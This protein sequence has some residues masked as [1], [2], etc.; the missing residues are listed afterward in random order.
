MKKISIMHNNKKM[1]MRNFGI[2]ILLQI[3]LIT[4]C[5][6]KLKQNATTKEDDFPDEI[7][8]FSPYQSNPIFSGTGRETW[9]NQIRERGYIIKED[10]TYKMWFSG[11]NGDISSPKYLGYATSSD[12]ISWTRHADPI[13][14]KKWTEDIFVIKNKKTYYMFA[15][16]ENDIAHLLTSKDGLTWTEQGNLV[17]KKTNGETIP[18][19]YGTPV[20]W[21]ENKKWYLFYEK[22][23]LGIWAATSNDLINWTNIVD[24][25]VIKMGPT[26]YDA[27]AV[28]ANQIIKHKEKYYLYYHGS[29]NPNWADPNENALW[30]SSV[31]MSK[32]LINWKK[33]PKNPIIE[34]DYSSPILIKEGS[35]YRLYTMHEKVCLFEQKTN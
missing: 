21:I 13:F 27:G 23:D 2:H 18:P 35:K 28:A 8:N 33:Y 29:T 32:D 16:G 26:E 22:N 9:D 10:H 12:G 31:A 14:D 5:N 1:P 15:E 7:V 34:G 24:E 17:I 4:S 6:N 30:T 25:P 11:Y 20:I 19:P 3:L